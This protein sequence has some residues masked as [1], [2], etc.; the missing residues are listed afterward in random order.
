MVEWPPWDGAEGRYGRGVEG[1]GT[2]GFEKDGTRGAGAGA[3]RGKV[4]AHALFRSHD[5]MP[6]T[7]RS[8]AATAT[9]TRFTILFKGA[10]FSRSKGT[11]VRP[12]RH[13]ER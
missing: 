10:S 13:G 1:R 5:T 8:I 6:I 11:R 4:A 12:E 3:G 2:D 7:A 9:A